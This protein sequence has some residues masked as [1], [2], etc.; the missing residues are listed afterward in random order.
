M[1]RRA[2]G[3][4]RFKSGTFKAA[5]NSGSL[6]RLKAS[7]GSLI[8]IFLFLFEGF[9]VQLTFSFD[10]FIING[11]WEKKYDV[12]RSLNVCNVTFGTGVKA[13][14]KRGG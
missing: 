10:S 12:G 4:I 8:L 13:G 11:G 6:I 2:E 3:D 9:Q 1:A 5:R 14:K 7:S